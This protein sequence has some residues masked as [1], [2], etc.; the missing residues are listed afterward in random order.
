[1]SRCFNPPLKEQ[2][3][4]A[5]QRCQQPKAALNRFPFGGTRNRRF[6][7]GVVALSRSI[8]GRF[9]HFLLN[10]VYQ[11]I[12]DWTW[13]Y[14]GKTRFF[15]AWLCFGISF[16]SLSLDIYA[17]LM[18]GGLPAF[19]AIIASPLLI[20]ILTYLWAAS[21][22]MHRQSSATFGFRPF[23]RFIRS[24]TMISACFFAVL[25]AVL[26]FR[27]GG[28]VMAKQGWFYVLYGFACSSALYFVEAKPPSAKLAW[29]EAPESGQHRSAS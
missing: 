6:E 13:Q 12:S 3:R 2:F 23:D 22:S 27:S 15:L 26:Y 16:V 28:L 10:R 1:M 20:L 21:A 4:K 18:R 14:S 7:A 25:S 9:D 11:P 29:E 5:E 17:S 24:V 8:V 19:G